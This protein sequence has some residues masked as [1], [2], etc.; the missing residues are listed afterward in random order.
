M[1]VYVN[2]GLVHHGAKVVKFP[3]SA[4]GRELIRNFA[5][6]IEQ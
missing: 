5:A 1:G 6:A 2:E 3:K 4:E